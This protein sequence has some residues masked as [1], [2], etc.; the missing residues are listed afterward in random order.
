MLSDDSLNRLTNF[1]V[2]LPQALMN[3]FFYK[4]DRR[5]SRSS[6]S[7]YYSSALTRSLFRVVG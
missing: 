5:I 6:R 1:P 7:D 2:I 3:F 4:G